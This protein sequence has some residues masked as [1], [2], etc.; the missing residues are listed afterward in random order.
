M[1]RVR[2]DD[3]V[4]LQ[5]TDEQRALWAKAA[6]D[7]GAPL[8]SFAMWAVNYMARYTIEVRTQGIQRKED[9]ILLRLEEKK[10]LRAVVDASW[11]A[12]D[13]LPPPRENPIRGGIKDPKGDLR[14]A[15]EALQDFL[16]EHQEEYRK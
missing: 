3:A 8:P 16:L 14:K 11:H 7:G 1:A 5:P 13:F 9:P 4:T 6:S 15:L 10:L 2:N 12:L